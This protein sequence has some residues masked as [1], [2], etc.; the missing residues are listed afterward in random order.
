MK[1]SDKSS[2]NSKSNGVLPS[3]EEATAAYTEAVEHYQHLRDVQRAVRQEVAADIG[4]QHPTMRQHHFYA[5]V[6]RTP[7]VRAA[8]QQL[9]DAFGMY[10]LRGQVLTLAMAR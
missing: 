6:G 10:Q 4:T 1:D 2:N 7:R 9:S 3:V 8:A 5:V